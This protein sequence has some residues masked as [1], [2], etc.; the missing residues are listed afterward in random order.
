MK[1]FWA[2]G[3]EGATLELLLEAMG[4][5]TAPSLYNAFGSKEDLFRQTVDLYVDTIGGS[6]IRALENATSARLAI[7]G[8]LQAVVEVAMPLRGPR[9][10]FLISSAGKCAQG[11][12]GAADYVRS[13][14]AK[15][16]SAI[17]GRLKR[18]VAEGDLSPKVDV[19]TIAS[20]Y[21]AII[22]GIGVRAG[23][24]ATR[25]ELNAIVESA[26]AAWEALAGTPP[27]KSARLPKHG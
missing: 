26:M 14:R 12:E 13:V 15:G 7:E 17:K 3:Y 5:I 21:Y 25:Q 22:N 4:G 18:A 1:V 11:N 27:K 19:D 2:R 8:M 9:G 6:T 10:C 20:F 23:D 24:G 16:P